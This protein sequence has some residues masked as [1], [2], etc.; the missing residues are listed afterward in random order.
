MCLP[1]SLRK[2]SGRLISQ[3]A[4]GRRHGPCAGQEGHQAARF[5]GAVSARAQRSG[6][7]RAADTRVTPPRTSL[8]LSGRRLESARG[9]RG[10]PLPLQLVGEERRLAFTGSLEGR[11]RLRR[12]DGVLKRGDTTVSPD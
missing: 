4:M 9:A 10:V 12:A 2:T 1:S 6:S 11:G 7:R 8:V 5:R 3:T